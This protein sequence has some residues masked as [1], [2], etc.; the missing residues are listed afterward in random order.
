VGYSSVGERY[1]AHP[2]ILVP[3]P[4]I[5]SGL[6]LRSAGDVDAQSEIQP[7]NQSSDFLQPAYKKTLSLA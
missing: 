2:P 4:G 1:L 7:P 6:A 3:H 5:D